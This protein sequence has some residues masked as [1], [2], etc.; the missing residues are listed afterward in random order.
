MTTQ[1]KF[2]IPIRV[3]LQWAPD[4]WGQAKSLNWDTCEGKGKVYPYSEIEMTEYLF[5]R[6]WHK[7]EEKGIKECP[8]CFGK[9]YEISKIRELQTKE[10]AIV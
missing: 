5:Q 7:I 8:S 9:G 6:E 3:D 4:R 1:A 10:M 2:D